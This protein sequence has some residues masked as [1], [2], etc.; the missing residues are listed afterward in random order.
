MGQ[1]LLSHVHCTRDNQSE[2]KNV[3]A[4]NFWAGSETRALTICTIS[5]SSLRP[6]N[7]NI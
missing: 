5:S 2:I 7:P 1:V 3:S 4:S 6:P